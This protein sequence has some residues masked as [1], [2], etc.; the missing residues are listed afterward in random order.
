MPE[1]SCAGASWTVQA[2]ENLL[3]ALNRAGLRVPYSCRA[4]SCHACL[5]R[6]VSGEPVDL[7]PEALSREQHG[8]GWRLACQ[9][10]VEQ[11]LRVDVFDPRRDGFAARVQ[12]LA[13]MA[14]GVL[15]LRL[16]P[17]RAL[18]YRA[19]QH[20]LL[21]NAE[22]DARPY[23]L[24]SLPGEEPWLEFHLDCSRPG[25]FCDAARRLR[26]GD[27]LRLGELHGGALHYDPD[28]SERPLLLLAAG[29][30]MA[31]LWSV[32]REALRQG[33][34]GPIRLLHFARGDHY[35]AG[36]L[37][38]LASRCEN[39]QLE[40]VGEDQRAGCLQALHP[41]SRQAIALICGRPA[42]VEACAKRLFMAGLP[43]GQVFS[44]AFVEREGA[45]TPP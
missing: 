37:T 24:A 19:G 31:P 22:G 15:R 26:T 42:F 40:W 1:L 27:G 45:G 9:C 29:T 4:G 16:L 11:D 13:W 12:D 30:G 17:E 5:V 38:E 2:G 28:W 44:D 34:R 8:R 7:Q 25:A 10:R 6:C 23:S 14:D 21:W 39:L 18:R 43:R 32:L 20:V 33:H 36:P 3:D 41:A 35:L